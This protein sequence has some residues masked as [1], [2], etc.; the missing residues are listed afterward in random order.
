VNPLPIP[1]QKLLLWADHTSRPANPD[2]S[3]CFR[4][5][6]L[7]SFNHKTS[8]KCSRPPESRLAMQCNH[9]IP[10]NQFQ[11][12]LKDW[13]RGT[14]AVREEQFCEVKSRL[15]ENVFILRFII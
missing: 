6:K 11:E 15:F 10:V 13:L 4:R 1:H 14:A 8:A 5:R 2:P 12:S 9:F 7:K 3:H